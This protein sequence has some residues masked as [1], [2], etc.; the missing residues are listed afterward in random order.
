M[1][2]TDAL[3][4]QQQA[5]ERVFPGE[6]ALDGAKAF[7]GDG[8]IEMTLA[9]AFVLFAVAGIL[10]TDCGF[11]EGAEFVCEPHREWLSELAR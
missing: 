7:L 2:D 8:L 4:A 6:H 11:S 3:E 1:H 9:A 5:A 10:S